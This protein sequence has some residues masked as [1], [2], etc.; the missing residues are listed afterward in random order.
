[1][2]GIERENNSF[3]IIFIRTLLILCYGD[4]LKRLFSFE[5]VFVVAMFGRTH[6]WLL[7]Q[8]T[9]RLLKHLP[10]QHFQWMDVIRLTIGILL[11]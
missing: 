8:E 11:S 5:F 4:K 9:R 3:S 6:V 2:A 10:K 7:S 1:M